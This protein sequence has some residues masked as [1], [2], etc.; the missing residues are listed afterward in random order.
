MPS[1]T[2]DRS[3][4]S[5]ARIH[6]HR[7]LSQYTPPPLQRLQSRIDRLNGAVDGLAD[8]RDHMSARRPLHRQ[9]HPAREEG[10]RLAVERRGFGEIA[11]QIDVDMLGAA[12][13]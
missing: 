10:L 13:S 4:F 7:Q 1:S 9:S 5:P 12:L 11:R 2:A 8:V 3:H 6:D